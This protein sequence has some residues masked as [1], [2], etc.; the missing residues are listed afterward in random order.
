MKLD[1]LII[2]I[3][4]KNL[5]YKQSMSRAADNIEIHPTKMVRK[6]KNRIHLDITR[7][8]NENVFQQTFFI[9]LSVS[10]SDKSDI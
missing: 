8:E 7:C 10:F 4:V 3:F 2:F 1:D 9:F 5:T 6:K